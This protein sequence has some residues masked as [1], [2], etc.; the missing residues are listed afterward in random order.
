MMSFFENLV[1]GVSG[2]VGGAISNR[3]AESNFNKNADLQRQFAKNGIRWRVEDAKAAG[4]HPL[5]ALGANTT[6]FSPIAVQDSVGPALATMGQDISRSMQATRTA[7]ERSAA[8]QQMTALSLE[9][10]QLENDLL[11]SQI[12]KNAT[13]G[14]P[15]PSATAFPIGSDGIVTRDLVDVQPSKIISARSE[16]S[17][18]EAGP[19]SPSWKEVDLGMMGKWY[20]PGSQMAESLE[21][22]ELAKYGAMIG[23]NFPESVMAWRK[24]NSFAQESNKPGW[25]KRMEKE[26]GV[27]M[28]SPRKGYWRFIDER[29]P[30]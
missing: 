30:Y 19:A 20:V 22:M 27:K 18:T 26:Q 25:V 16:D 28:W 14:P 29:G 4:L 2:L 12:A 5:F 8:S 13:V 10:A 24:F 3:A 1:S 17:S 7:E 6:S 9:R 23:K 11:R 21:D 15:M